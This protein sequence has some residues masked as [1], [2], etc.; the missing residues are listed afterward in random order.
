[1]HQVSPGNPYPDPLDETS[2]LL[3]KG[4]PYND[5]ELQREVE[6]SDV[7]YTVSGIPS[8]NPT[9]PTME[10]IISPSPTDIN[11]GGEPGEGE[12]EAEAEAGGG[13]YAFNYDGIYTATYVAKDT[14]GNIIRKTRKLGVK[15]DSEPPKIIELPPLEHFPF[16][17]VSEDGT[18]YTVDADAKNELLKLLA[19]QDLKVS[20][21]FYPYNHFVTYLSD[22]A[23]DITV[24]IL[25]DN[26]I[27]TTNFIDQY[28]ATSTPPGGVDI[29]MTVSDKSGN[30]S[31]IYLRKLII[32]DQQPPTLIQFPSIPLTMNI[33]ASL[34]AQGIRDKII[35]ISSN[36]D[37]QDNLVIFSDDEVLDLPLQIESI[38]DGNGIEIFSIDAVSEDVAVGDNSMDFSALSLPSP[39]RIVYTTTDG[40]NP[41]ETPESLRTRILILED[42]IPPVIDLNLGL[43]DK[44]FFSFLLASTTGTTIDSQKAQL[45]SEELMILSDNQTM[46]P[47]DLSISA[48]V[49]SSTN[50][51]CFPELPAT[52]DISCPGKHTVTITATD[53]SLNT[54]EYPQSILV[55]V[56][57]QE[58]RDAFNEI[59]IPGALD[60]AGNTLTT[61]QNINALITIV[62]QIENITMD[63]SFNSNPIYL[64]PPAYNITPT[65]RFDLS[66]FLEQQ[67][68]NPITHNIKMDFAPTMGKYIN[69][70]IETNGDKSLAFTRPQ[71]LTVDFDKS[72]LITTQGEVTE[73]V[74]AKLEVGTYAELIKFKVRVSPIDNTNKIHHLIIPVFHKYQPLL[75][76]QFAEI[77]DPKDLPPLE[78][79][80]RDLEQIVD[81]IYN[82]N[83]VRSAQFI[84][85]NYGG[86]Y[87]LTEVAKDVNNGIQAHG[88]SAFTAD[89]VYVYANHDVAEFILYG[90][91]DLK[92]KYMD[93]VVNW[94][95]STSKQVQGLRDI[96][97]QLIDPDTG[98]LS[99]R[100]LKFSIITIDKD[101]P[102]D[103]GNFKPD[104][105]HSSST[106]EVLL[107]TIPINNACRT[108]TYSYKDPRDYYLFEVLCIYQNQRF[109]PIDEMIE[110]ADDALGYVG[111]NLFIGYTYVVE[112]VVDVD[113]NVITEGSS[114]VGW[115]P[116]STPEC[117][118]P[119]PGLK[120]GLEEFNFL[121]DTFGLATPQPASIRNVF[122]NWNADEDN[123]P[124]LPYSISTISSGFVN[125]LVELTVGDYLSKYIF[126]KSIPK[127][128]Y[129]SILMTST[130]PDVVDETTSTPPSIS[131]APNPHYTFPAGEEFSFTS[132]GFIN[133]AAGSPLMGSNP[134]NLSAYE[135]YIT[136]PDQVI[137]LSLNDMKDN[138][139]IYIFDL[140][141]QSN[142]L[143]NQ[144]ILKLDVWAGPVPDLTQKEYFLIEKRVNSGSDKIASINQSSTFGTLEPWPE[145]EAG[146]A[147]WHVEEELGQ[148]S[149]K[150]E[151]GSE[152]IFVP[153]FKLQPQPTDPIT[154]TNT[155]DGVETGVI[156]KVLADNLVKICHINAGDNPE[157]EIYDADCNVDLVIS[158]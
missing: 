30:I 156:I 78:F 52:L 98:M 32:V 95:R 90:N 148:P 87:G 69:F 128:D 1:M 51:S 147:V 58:S 20:D 83:I 140:N 50:V 126:S 127:I 85:Q 34:T 149:V 80:P 66:P 3:A 88:I 33:D 136:A 25:I 129:Q 107:K 39:L 16:G 102:F 75:P 65:Q 113:G 86:N 108:N 141:P 112:E 96:L 49:I 42:T 60:E 91:G 67:Y 61:F 94:L 84:N 100:K 117:T 77:E 9:D 123:P 10:I 145:N 57:D 28:L 157:D 97:P 121:S 5:A 119:S 143:Y 53:G 103:V 37:D 110:A 15:T 154:S 44:N 122:P 41:P 139:K 14:N 104:E 74:T 38:T 21:E 131:S 151:G 8:F 137:Q 47:M 13:S 19:S 68:D 43:L 81:D 92:P 158:E 82:E 101:L 142:G 155:N 76:E 125:S 105:Y 138:S 71:P 135:K 45:L 40:Y 118:T 134:S 73:L 70:Y 64:T 7:W 109:I 55:Y 146:I 63:R 89:N 12:G 6:L 144:N 23:S 29:P 4:Q 106:N 54:S 120:G 99:P 79:I 22:I 46:N 93:Q 150:K 133:A 18:T 152:V 36:V 31:H 2:I 111:D 130:L 17:N 114:T 62:Q 56:Y 124:S 26:P 116:V 153:G 72:T 115:C 24:E 132:N 35:Q 59:V 27:F 11:T 48:Q